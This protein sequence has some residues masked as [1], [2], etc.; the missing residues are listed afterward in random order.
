MIEI[1]GGG[2]TW[3]GLWHIGAHVKE[4]LFHLSSSKLGKWYKNVR[5]SVPN[6]FPKDAWS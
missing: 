2:G 1:V 4:Y 5:N 6:V 3:L